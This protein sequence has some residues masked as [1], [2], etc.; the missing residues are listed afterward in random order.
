[1]DRQDVSFVTTSEVTLTNGRCEIMK[2]KVKNSL[3]TIDRVSLSTH[4]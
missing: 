1:M 2:L 3:T 4:G